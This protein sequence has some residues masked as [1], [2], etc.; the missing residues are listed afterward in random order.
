MRLEIGNRVAVL[1]DVLKGI[2]TQINGGEI[3]IKTNDGMLFQFSASELVRVDK[4]QQELSKFSD[5]NN[6]LLKE[7]IS[8]KKAK[9]SNFKKNKN[10]KV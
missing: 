10:E 6:P 8:S 4:D 9:K 1:D 2:I 3:T 5:I 7:K